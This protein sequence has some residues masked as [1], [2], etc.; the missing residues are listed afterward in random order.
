MVEP[1][2]PWPLPGTTAQQDAAIGAA[3]KAEREAREA[4]IQHLLRRM[5]ALSGDAVSRDLEWPLSHEGKVRVLR[6]EILA[7]GGAPDWPEEPHAARPVAW[8]GRLVAWWRRQP[9]PRQEP[10][11]T[12]MERPTD[13]PWGWTAQGPMPDWGRAERPKDGPAVRPP[14]ETP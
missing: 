1:I 7:L 13:P 3:R 14:K 6:R 11:Y 2:H 10:D 4:E 12:R 8:W 5:F 9:L